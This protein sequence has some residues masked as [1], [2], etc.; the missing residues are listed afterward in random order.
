MSR[1]LVI[2]T[3]SIA[4]YKAC[5]AIS[6]LVQQG[7]SVR[8]VLTA[9]A[10]EFVGTATLEG[11]TREKVAVAL[12]EP[13]AALDHITLA[14]WAD[15]VLVCPATAGFM[16]RVA[17]GLAD[18]LAGALLL[19]HDWRKPL[20]F[21]PAMNPGM[22]AHPAT[23]GAVERLRGWG[24]RFIQPR[25]G[26]TACGEVGEG[27]LAEPDEIVAG[28]VDVAN[29]NQQRGGDSPP[30]PAA[31][32]RLRVLITSGGTSEPIDGV[33]VLTNL[34]TGETGARMADALSDAGHEVFLLRASNASPARHVQGEQTFTSFADLD[35]RLREV[36]VGREFDA[37][38][39]AAAV[40]DFKVAAV[41]VN[42]IP[43][44]P[45]DHKLRSD[46]APVLRL[47]PNPKLVASLRARSRNPAI[48]VV[49]FK[50]THGASFEEQVEAIN[51]LLANGQA[52]FVVHNDLAAR[53]DAAFPATVWARDRGLV[54]RCADRRDIA[55]ALE[56]ILLSH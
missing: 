34:S 19:A 37:V 10:R 32:R 14:R 38:I 43:F 21:A 28:V 53:R 30:A 52:D 12:F 7:H 18:D 40:S 23:Q 25:A 8:T 17:A 49:A 16:N 27:R 56:E 22:W 48:Q 13:G 54:A 45:G 46:T 55:P 5:A 11:L 50:L 2:L 47:A 20:L 26:R 39:H 4:C 31:R 15:V 24:A 6:T 36:L 35:A 51:G 44:A 29:Q 41:E 9:A 1:I 3:G 42:G 33:R